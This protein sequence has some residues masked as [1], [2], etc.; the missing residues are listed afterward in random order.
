MDYQKQNFQDGEVLTAEKLNHMED[1]IKN[2]T[3]YFSRPNLLDN[4]Y[5]SDPINQRGQTIYDTSSAGGYTLDRWWSIFS[6][7]KAVSGGASVKSLSSTYGGH[8]RQAIEAP[9]R[10][11]GKTVTASILVKE[12]SGT[13]RLALLKATGMNSGQAAIQSVPVTVGLNMFSVTLPDDIGT[14]SYPYC[15]LTVSTSGDG[16]IVAEAVK[17]E[18]GDTQTL[19]HQENG[20]WVLNEIP[21][22]AEELAKCKQYYLKMQLTG[23]VYYV[24]ANDA[25][26]SLR[27]PT[28][29]RTPKPSI[30]VV[31]G[32]VN[33]LRD[34]WEWSFPCQKDYVATLCCTKE[35][36]GVPV[37]SM[38]DIT[39]EFHAD[40]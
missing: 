17:L 4:W 14:E 38:A 29:M 7:V 3:S 25:Y 19:A 15:L 27:V 1:G 39:V 11:Q 32:K 2:V 24:T 40:L 26:V 35:S 21:N 33:N 9:A 5:F 16:Q 6:E 30:S 31:S 22:Y 20:K 8:L 13:A 23:F 12:V 37:N 34:V 36:H 10:L 28:V 18:L